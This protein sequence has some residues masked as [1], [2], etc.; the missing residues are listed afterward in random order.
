MCNVKKR[1][2]ALQLAFVASCTRPQ[3]LLL[4][5]PPDAHQTR[6]DVYAPP[7]SRALKKLNFNPPPLSIQLTD[8]IYTAGKPPLGPSTKG[9]A[10][11]DVLQ[12]LHVGWEKE[13]KRRCG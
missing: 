7:H 9:G 1:Q 10:G 12:Y 2:L 4:S 6:T 8:W 11:V 5:E 3:L 13:E